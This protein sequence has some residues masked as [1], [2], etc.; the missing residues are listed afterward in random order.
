MS[1]EL[2][3]L[4][5][6][7]LGPLYG[8][9]EELV[10]DSLPHLYRAGLRKLVDRFTRRSKERKL[11]ELTPNKSVTFEA[12][13]SISPF[14]T[15]V[16]SE[17]LAGILLS[18]GVTKADESVSLIYLIRQLSSSQLLLHYHIY[19][20]LGQQLFQKYAHDREEHDPTRHPPEG[21]FFDCSP[22][23]SPS[24]TVDLA[25]LEHH[26]LIGSW[27][28]G[29]TTIDEDYLLNYA[30][31]TRSTLGT[32]LYAAAQNELDGWFVFGKKRYEAIHGIEPSRF[33][34]LVT[35]TLN[36][37]TSLALR[38]RKQMA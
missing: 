18:S 5:K 14:H 33:P 37:L 25:V 31:V 32:M 19:H 34:G 11:E 3:E 36:H 1:S 29:S 20:A 15:T 10:E 23:T 9:V 7:L 2:I 30:H 17:Y 6:Q 13:R 35:L 26:S 28:T 12:I 27:S 38:R 24:L 4:A 22:L 16:Q 21:V 8:V